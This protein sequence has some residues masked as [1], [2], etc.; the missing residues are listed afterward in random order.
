ME[1][2]GIY[3]KLMNYLTPRSLSWVM[4]D[5]LTQRE[6]ISI[7]NN[8]DDIKYSR[9]DPLTMSSETIVSNLSYNFFRKTDIGYLI[10]KTLLKKRLKEKSK[11]SKMDPV[12]IRDYMGDVKNIFNQNRVGKVLW[13]ILT[14]D[15]EEVNKEISPFIH[16]VEKIITSQQK[17]EKKEIKQVKK[18]LN[19]K[20]EPS[21]SKNKIKLK[22]E[23]VDKE[24]IRELEEKIKARDNTI[25]QLMGV[26]KKF[27]KDNQKL[28]Q[29]IEDLQKD[30]NKIAG[31]IEDAKKALF[32]QEMLFKEKKRLEKEIKEYKDAIRLQED[33]YTSLV[34][35]QR[36]NLQLRG[37]IIRWELRFRKLQRRPGI[38]TSPEKEEITDIPR[39]GV[40]VDVQNIYYGAKIG[41][42]AKLNFE[43]LL[44]LVTRDRQLVAAIA[45]IVQTPEINQ[46]EFIKALERVGYEV[47]SKD[48]RRRA[49]GSAKGDWDLGI[50]M[51][52]ISL[53]DKMDVVV[54][55]SGDGDFIDLIKFLRKSDVEVEVA[56][57]QH[58]TSR[59]LI[60]IA[61]TFYPMEEDMIIT[62]N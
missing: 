29:K 35:L 54:L 18:I 19:S 22:D 1:D 11:L 21:P 53:Q 13:C 10:T 27:R 36:K 20:K 50:A 62:Y 6:I 39:V 23:P 44:N 56:A 38:E 2:G 51:D 47:K 45:Y 9:K 59:D 49:D 31:E 60:E 42:Q 34:L 32:N 12:A 58:N 48:L 25:N 41:Y 3:Q 43:T 7:L 28:N 15:R 33:L 57:F 16:S 26:N 30:N 52:I 61:H 14:D 17:N 46:E 5:L 8:S 40:F 37:E 55:V 4:N 24:K